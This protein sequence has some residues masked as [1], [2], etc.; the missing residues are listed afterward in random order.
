M[1]MD[2]STVS[3][4]CGG[5]GGDRCTAGVDVAMAASMGVMAA[6]IGSGQSFSLHT[7][8]AIADEDMG[9]AAD[10]DDGNRDDDDSLIAVVVAA[11]CLTSLLRYNEDEYEGDEARKDDMSQY[12][13][14]EVNDV[15][16][17]GKTAVPAAAAAAADVLCGPNNDAGNRKNRAHFGDSSWA[18]MS[19]SSSLSS[20]VR[21]RRR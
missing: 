9:R 16:D 18:I 13:A 2:K 21:R 6:A 12:D 3:G 1:I 14:R 15:S 7:D 8:E 4:C 11:S 17:D 20:R 19:S 5:G 10:E